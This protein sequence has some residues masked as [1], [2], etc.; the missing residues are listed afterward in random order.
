MPNFKVG[1]TVYHTGDFDEEPMEIVE[2]RAGDPPCPGPNQVLLED[3]SGRP[4]RFIHPRQWEE[5]EYLYMRGEK[6]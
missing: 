4:D 3:R 1:D 2:P 6:Q 5:I